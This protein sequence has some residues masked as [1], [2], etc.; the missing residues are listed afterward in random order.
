MEPAA[1]AHTKGDESVSMENY[2]EDLSN[3][4]S[5]YIDPDD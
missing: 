3:T 1:K 5:G 2:P 4:D